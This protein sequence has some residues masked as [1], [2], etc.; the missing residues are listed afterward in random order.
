[1]AFLLWCANQK[2]AMKRPLSQIVKNW[3]SPFLNRGT[4][5]KLAHSVR[6]A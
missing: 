2:D 3:R 4:A 6:V 1:V 5:Q